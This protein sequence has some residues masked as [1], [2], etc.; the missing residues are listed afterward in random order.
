MGADNIFL[1]VPADPGLD[2]GESRDP[3]IPAL[4]RRIGPPLSRFVQLQP[5]RTDPSILFDRVDAGL[6]E[7]WAT[8]PSKNEDFAAIA[9][10]VGL[11]VWATTSIGVPRFREQ[12]PTIAVVKPPPVFIA[13]KP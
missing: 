12:G 7:L 8:I 10:F 1:V 11:N 5:S 13:L 2:P 4:M 3:S 6:I 9:A